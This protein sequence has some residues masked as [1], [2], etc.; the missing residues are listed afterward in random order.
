M[1]TPNAVSVNIEI[2]W[3]AKFPGPSTGV[4]WALRAQ[5]V[6]KRVRN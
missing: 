6:A 3:V 1:E 2:V 5:R 4:I